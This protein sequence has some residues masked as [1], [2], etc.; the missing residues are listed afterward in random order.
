VR[1]RDDPS[2]TLLPNA[3]RGGGGGACKISKHNARFRDGALVD[4]RL[5]ERFTNQETI[6]K[7][8]LVPSLKRRSNPYALVNI[9]VYTC[10]DCCRADFSPPRNSSVLC[11]R[12]RA[13][14]LWINL[15]NPESR[16]LHRSRRR[17][18]RRKW[19]LSYKP[20]SV[21]NG[22]RSRLCTLYAR[23]RACLY[24]GRRTRQQLKRSLFL[25]ELLHYYILCDSIRFFNVDR[26]E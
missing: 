20:H 23:A 24:T 18:K 12:A 21:G 11:A 25:V 26:R 22:Y 7:T 4:R 13:G 19:V 10:V 3:V 16:T 5:S 6:R 15:R 14:K 2:R 17:R 8:L 9:A 1:F